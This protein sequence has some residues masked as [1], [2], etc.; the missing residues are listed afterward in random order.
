LTGWKKNYAD[1]KENGLF[2]K[3]DLHM[4]TGDFEST[5]EVILNNGIKIRLTE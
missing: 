4:L 3:V 2:V 1:E 5:V